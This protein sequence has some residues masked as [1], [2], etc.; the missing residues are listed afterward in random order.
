[1][2]SET[3]KKTFQEL[4][5]QEIYQILDLRAKVFIMEQRI[6]YVD[7]DYRD[8]KSIH[9]LIKDQDK[10]ICYLRL[11][12]PKVKY[13]EYALSRVVTDPEFRNK[14]LATR[15]I[16]EAM[17]DIKGHPIRISGQAYLRTYYEGLGFR[18]V[19]GP[20]MEED[21]LHFEMFHENG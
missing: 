20:Y 15:I 17:K 2:L 6:L 3:A 16:Q 10:L 4:T 19:K 7:T 11:I 13:E 1:M 18:V 5:N 8:Q 12:L 21:I 14:G 9:Y